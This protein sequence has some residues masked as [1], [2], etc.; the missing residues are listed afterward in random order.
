MLIR[1][2]NGKT[3]EVEMETL[4][5][6]MYSK[7]RRENEVNFLF[8]ELINLVKDLGLERIEEIKNV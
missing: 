4:I 2:E 8:E 6:D 7:C 1:S 3:I 5:A